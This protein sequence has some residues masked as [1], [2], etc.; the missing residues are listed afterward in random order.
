MLTLQNFETEINAAILQRGKL[1]FEKGN[2]ENLEETEDNTWCA[3]VEGADLYTVEITLKANKTVTN[4]SCDCPYDEGI[5]KHIV[6]VLFALRETGKKQGAKPKIA[7]PKDVF[8][9][10]LQTISLNEYQNFISQYAAKNKNFKTEFELYFADKDSRIDVGKNYLD[11]VEKMIRKHSHRGYIDYRR[12]A[13]FS[14]EVNTILKT[15]TAYLSK[16]NFM[17]AFALAKSVLKPLMQVMMDSD[18]SNGSIGDTVEEAIGIMENIATANAAAITI[19]EQL[20]GFLTKELASEIYFDYGDFGYHMFSIFKNLA[21]QL[22]TGDVFLGFI[23]A[24]LPNLVGEYKGYRKDFFQTQ[25]IE[26]L[27]LTGKANEV[28]NLIHQNMDIVEVRQNEV[29]KAIDKKDFAMA[30]KL[31]AEGIALAESKAHPGTVSEWQKDLLR[32]AM[33]QNNIATIRHYT[34][35]FAFERGLSPDYY[36]QLKK[37]YPAPEW[38]IFIEK[39]IAETIQEITHKWDRNKNKLWGHPAHPPLLQSLAPIYIQEKYWDRLLALVQQENNLHTTLSY[40][41]YLVKIYP[42]ELLKI[43]LPT[44]ESYGVK[45]EG[46]GAYKDLVSKMKLI[47]KDIPAGKEKVIELAQKLRLQFSVKPRR[48]AM[49]EELDKILK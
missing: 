22:N 43:Y 25:K 23:D 30:K 4:Y 41:N 8:K 27:Q 40:H 47:I 45:A 37:T 14:K 28:E 35:H 20:F 12:T 1:Y 24:R 11:L 2:V 34:K 13:G 49:M 39:L 29:N 19:K 42:A 33:L 46:R 6:A 5:C 26:F 18:D 36:N 17:D 32:I 21:V 9:N 38:K 31:I 3:E 48:P 7:N 15:G 10:L 16:N 44:L